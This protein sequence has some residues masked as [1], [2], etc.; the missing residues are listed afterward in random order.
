MFFFAE[1]GK[2]GWIALCR[3]SQLTKPNFEADPYRFFRS[4]YKGTLM[5][6]GGLS[7]EKV[8]S[9]FMDIFMNFW[10]KILVIC[11]HMASV[12]LMG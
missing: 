2:I 9:Q 10:S 1:D 5:I 11:P 12:I 7:P 8:I 4:H 6:N 3:M